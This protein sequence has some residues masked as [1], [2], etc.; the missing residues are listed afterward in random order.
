MSI[1]RKQD[2]TPTHREDDGGPVTATTTERGGEG[3]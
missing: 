2:P 1:A 3:E